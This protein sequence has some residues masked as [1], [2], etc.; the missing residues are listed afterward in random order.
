MCWWNELPK[1]LGRSKNTAINGVI[2]E[3][4]VKCKYDTKTGFLL[5]MK[6]TYEFAVYK[7]EFS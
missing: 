1:L 2:E 7:Q 4:E 5:E 3:K 6:A